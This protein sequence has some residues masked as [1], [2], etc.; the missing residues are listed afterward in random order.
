[1]L[2]WPQWPAEE[3][4]MNKKRILGLDRYSGLYLGAFFILLFG[5]WTPGQFLTISTVQIIASQESVAAL[6]A[7]AL[8]IPLVVGQFDLS[9]GFMANLAGL[10]ATVLMNNHHI[11]V[12]L[13]MAISVAVG[14]AI[15]F[16]NAYV[17]VKLKVNSFIATLGMGSILGALTTIF[18]GGQTPLPYVDT[19][20]TGLTQT[21]IFGFQIVVV[22]LI[23]VALVVWWILSQT[24]IGRRMYATGANSDA[25]RLSGVRTNRLAFGSLIASAGIA[26]LAGVL[27]TS[28]T[29]PSLTFGQTLL[30]PAFAACF[31]GATQ[32]L[33]GRFNVGGTLLAIFVLAIGVTGLQLVTSVS[34][35]TDMFDGV[36]LI[37]AVALSVT[38]QRRKTTGVTSGRTGKNA[39]DGEHGIDEAA[40]APVDVEARPTP[41]Q[42]EAR[43][44]PG[45]FA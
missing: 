32:I 2:T 20:W 3:A 11:P 41:A 44:A 18:T 19:F 8:L 24:P 12:L 10:L 30:L 38:Q 23:V 40:P 17:V 15:G 16:I 43:P 31:L 14:L 21:K 5:I 13:A 1:M 45:T 36:A 6:V 9:V 42:V 28:L 35:V 22:Y 4:E 27:F 7:L 34:W 39:A 25:A 26:S 33:P 37:V 29:G